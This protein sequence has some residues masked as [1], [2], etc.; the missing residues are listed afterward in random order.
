MSGTFAGIAKVKRSQRPDYFKKEGNY[1]VELSGLVTGETR[2]SG[3]PFFIIE[4]Y[5]VSAEAVP[6]DEGLNL[7]PE[8]EIHYAGQWVSQY[9]SFERKPNGEL[10]ER[11]T[12]DLQKAKKFFGEVLGGSAAGI[13]DADITEEALTCIVRGTQLG[14][15]SMSAEAVA[16]AAQAEGLPNLVDITSMKMHAAIRRGISKKGNVY[17]DVNWGAM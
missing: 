2:D 6:P 9:L 7:P 16:Q 10:T 8:K 5:V 4:A 15:A 3:Q 13:A 1:V 14:V 17:S 12:M 11:G